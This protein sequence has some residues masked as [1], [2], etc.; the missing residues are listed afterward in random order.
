[1]S[2]KLYTANDKK[3]AEDIA[4]LQ[5]K[6]ETIDANVNTVMTNHLPH[7]YERL[8]GIENKLAYYSGGLAIISVL[9]PILIK[10]FTK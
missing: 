3:E 10:I 6:V 7:I 2:R 8:G 1:M 9:V 5:T 4:V